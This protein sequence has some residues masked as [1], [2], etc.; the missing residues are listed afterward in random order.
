[1]STAGRHRLRLI[2][3]LIV[4]V[5]AFSSCIPDSRPGPQN[6]VPTATRTTI[7]PSPSPV[8]PVPSPDPFIFDCINQV[9]TNDLCY[10]GRS[11]ASDPERLEAAARSFCDAHNH[12]GFCCILIWKDKG[13]VAQSFPMT[14]ANIHAQVAQYDR[15]PGVGIDCF[16]LLKNNQVVA[17]TG[18]C[19]E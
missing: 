14:E 12:Q 16:T 11:L 3:P 6:T 5:A 8:L 10:A 19:I 15:D 1:M 13:S 7:P 18:V 2:L 17:K 4:I 9:N